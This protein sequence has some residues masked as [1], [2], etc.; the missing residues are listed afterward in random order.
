M[1]WTEEKKCPQAHP[2]EWSRSINKIR[3]INVLMRK[4]RG[5]SI[6]LIFF[7]PAFNLGRNVQDF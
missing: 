2:G 1:K 6:K 4:D 5:G 7:S 3:K